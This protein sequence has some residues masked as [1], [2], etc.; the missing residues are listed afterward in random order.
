MRCVD[1]GQ[2][3]DRGIDR[4]LQLLFEQG[5]VR[6]SACSSFIGLSSSPASYLH[7]HM[8]VAL[9]PPHLIKNKVAGDSSAATS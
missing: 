6:E 3:G 5:S 8:R 4:F 2:T 1:S 9:L 7:V